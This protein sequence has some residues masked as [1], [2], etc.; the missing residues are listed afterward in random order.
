MTKTEKLLRELIALPSVNPAF[1]PPGDPNAGEHNVADFLAAT[2]TQAGLE[3]EFMPV[4]DAR[5]NV[6]AR[7]A[8]AGKIRQR[9]F[10]APHL[11]TV[12]G[13]KSQF[14]PIR[15]NG[16]IHGRGACDTK[17]CIAAM[18]MAL[19]ELA[20][21]GDRP[22]ETE[23][24]FAGLV[25]EENMQAG[26]RALASRFKADLA[27]VGEPTC[28]QVVTAH[29]GILWF[30]LETKGKSAHGAL[31]HLGQNAVHTMARIVDLLET[32]YATRLSRR[33]HPLLGQATVS[34]GLIHGGTQPNIVPDRC[35][36]L[37]DR[38]TLPGET[39][40]SVQR[41]I[42]TLLRQHG[43]KAVCTD[44]KLYPCFP[45]E[46][47]PALP[48]VQQF[49]RT[50]GQRRPAGVNYF[51]DASVLA[52]A[53]IPSVAFGPGNIAHAHSADEWISLASLE[54]SYA[55]LLRF[56]RSLP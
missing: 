39:R 13:D 18:M 51:C 32:Q 43:L 2:A 40:A 44:N 28:L 46:T 7:L 55:T 5:S 37:V 3:V 14:R 4:L 31:P 12:N 53:G 11:D 20:R 47:D 17:G 50:I 22:A 25:D 21:Q 15:K 45:L 56:L 8:P 27:I 23:V 24:V 29:K 36:I 35:H 9:I 49:M 16:C 34:V 6:L 19:C 1:L 54:S 41:E 38:R 30:R 52:H 26:S 10:L 42:Q 48:L 33:R